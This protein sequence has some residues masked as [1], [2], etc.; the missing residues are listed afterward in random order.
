MEEQKAGMTFSDLLRSQKE[1]KF[2]LYPM[3][4]QM[5]ILRLEG[6]VEN[7]KAKLS[8]IF[9]HNPNLVLPTENDERSFGKIAFGNV[10]KK[11]GSLKEDIEPASNTGILTNFQ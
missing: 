1:A 8:W 9:D 6:E 7:F 3:E 10:F 11:H 5:D 2:A 4:A